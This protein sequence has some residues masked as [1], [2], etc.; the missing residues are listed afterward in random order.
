MRVFGAS[1]LKELFVLVQLYYKIFGKARQPA[2]GDD[3]CTQQ[4][5]SRRYGCVLRFG[6]TTIRVLLYDSA[7]PMCSRIA[8]P[9]KTWRATT[10]ICGP[11]ESF[12]LAE[13][14][15]WVRCLEGRSREVQ[16]RIGGN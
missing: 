5:H 2:S 10:A 1:H 16:K 4:N 12:P 7:T 3:E 9:L 14:D 8:S 13:V 11:E 6:R 15:T